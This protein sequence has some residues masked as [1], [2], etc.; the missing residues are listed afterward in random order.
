MKNAEA[1]EGVTL[2]VALH[3][4]VTS[5]TLDDVLLFHVAGEVLTY[6]KICS[7]LYELSLNLEGS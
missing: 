1:Q 3:A 5:A 7:T 6:L 4:A 2:H